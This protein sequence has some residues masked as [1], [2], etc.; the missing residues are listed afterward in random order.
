MSVTLTGSQQ[1]AVAQAGVEPRV[2]VSIG[3]GYGIQNV[4]TEL[5]RW[6]GIDYA[7]MLAEAPVLSTP[8]GNPS[9]GQL[10]VKA[11]TLVLHNADGF[12]SQRPSGFYRGQTITAKE[13]VLGVESVALRTSTFRCT[14]THMPTGGAT[15]VLEAEDAWAAI[16]RAQVPNA[17]C[18][19][20]TRKYP[21]VG[22]LE[23]NG[24]TIPVVFGRA[25]VPLALVDDQSSGFYRYVACVG[26][27][28][29]I[30][31]GA[32]YERH[33]NTIAP[34]ASGS[35]TNVNVFSL[36]Y[37]VRNGVPVTE[38]TTLVSP[39][40]GDAVQRFADLVCN[41]PGHPDQ[42]L[43]GI[44]TDSLW[45]AG[46]APT[47]ISSTGLAEARA[48]YTANSMTFDCALTA[49]QTVEDWLGA[50]THDAMTGVLGRDQL[51]L[52][53][54]GSRTAQ[55]S[56]VAGN[57]VLGSVGYTDAPEMQ[58]ESQRVL[59]YR[60][61]SADPDIWTV[62][63][64]VA[65]SGTQSVRQSDFIG[66]R[67]VAMKVAEFWA[68]EA[69]AGVRTYGLQTTLRNTGI[70]EGDLITLTYSHADA[71][72]T[73]TRV[74]AVSRADGVHAM[75][76][77]RTETAVWEAA[78]I[79]ADVPFLQLYRMVV[80]PFTGSGTNLVTYASSHTLG[81]APISLVQETALGSLGHV[82]YT[83]SMVT[84]TA[85]TYSVAIQT[86]PTAGDT[87]PAFGGYL[88]GFRLYA[89]PALWGEG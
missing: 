29:I 10:A 74:Q 85:S 51:V 89:N 80:A 41:S 73:L 39:Y 43:L 46:L 20:D 78:D 26:T 54:Q 50:W 9:T 30:D 57:I 4:A 32:F 28:T 59:L 6:S 48:F 63:G 19:I 5:T 71:Q 81:S 86:S 53:H 15:F 7:G 62:V 27:G 75:T 21:N 33:N 64:W 13:V 77:R 3:T 55:G 82:T 35:G 70:E 47:I 79:P 87:S 67:S 22:T 60:E 2:L 49:T 72:G 58:E 65:S 76:L 1:T 45:G 17:A 66:R 18:R 14:A 16:R 83:T 23:A 61:R 88:L 68:K 40:Q 24:T 37:A 56:L 52:V 25:L 34:I 36:Q 69:A 44:V 42:V 11:L 31:S 84:A 38:F 8:I 12:W